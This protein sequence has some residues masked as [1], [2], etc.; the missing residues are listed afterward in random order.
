MREGLCKEM[1]N[2]KCMYPHCGCLFDVKDAE[3][4]CKWG[5]TALVEINGRNRDI[6]ECIAPLVDTLNKAGYRTIASCCGHGKQPGSIIYIEPESGE[7]K[8]MRL[9]TFKQAREV[10]E[11][12]PPIN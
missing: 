1:E 10:D 7:T 4:M 8:E 9:M 3:Q 2:G 6:D 11:L 5:H 12:F